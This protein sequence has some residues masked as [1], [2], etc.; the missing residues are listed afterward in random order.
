MQHSAFAA[1]AAEVLD[2]LLE[3]HPETASQLGDHRFDDRLDDLS[4]P[5]LDEEAQWVTRRLADLRA[6]P[7]AELDPADQVD[8][9]VL[10]NVLELRAYELGELRRARVGPAR[11][12]PRHRRLHVAG[13]RLRPAGRPAAVRRRPAG[14][15][16]R[17]ARL[18]APLARRTCRGC[19]SRPR[20]GSSPAPARCSRPSSSARSAPSRPCGRRSSR[21]ASGP[22][23][24]STSTSTG[25]APGWTRRR[26]TRGSARRRS[27]ASWP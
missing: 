18:G 21:C 26:A 6:V 7:L 25:C 3:R 8:A 23:R 11:R 17:C 20:S 24:R 5:A 9:Q 10:A 27:P 22:S 16:A 15:R 4:E 1:L 2:E 13:P 19:T 12:Q 14:R